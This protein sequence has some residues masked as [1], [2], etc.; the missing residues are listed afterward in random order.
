MEKLLV[1]RSA[2][3][4]FTVCAWIIV[5]FGLSLLV[6]FTPLY[7]WANQLHAIQGL[8]ELLG[9]VL[10]VAALPATGVLLIG[11]LLFCL[12]RDPA[13]QTHRFVWLFL[14]FSTLCFGAALYFFRNYRP[15]RASMMN[16]A[17]LEHMQKLVP[18]AAAVDQKPARG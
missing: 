16:E 9:G 14:F 7:D 18:E 6:V 12:L 5:V 11:M 10:L 8:L 1:T 3:I 15:L 13:P 4:T 2:Y 17:M